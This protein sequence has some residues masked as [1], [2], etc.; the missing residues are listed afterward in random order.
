MVLWLN[1]A[2]CRYEAEP[3]DNLMGEMSAVSLD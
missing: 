3:D 2:P 1:E